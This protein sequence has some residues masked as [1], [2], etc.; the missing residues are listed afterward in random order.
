MTEPNPQRDA[1]ILSIE[2]HLATHGPQRWALVRDRWPDI[3]EASWWRLVARAK[4]K[5]ADEAILEESRRKLA[6]RAAQTTAEEKA[7]AVAANLPATVSPDFVSKSGSRGMAQLDLLSKFES[8]FADAMLLREYAV[9]PEGKI[10]N[11][12]FFRDSVALRDKLLGTALRACESIWNLRRQI[13][14]YD[15]VVEEIAKASP[16]VAQ[17]IMERL[18][19]LNEECGMSFVARP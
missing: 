17:Q 6:E 2:E 16:E 18:Q 3:S 9:N 12:H 11:P 8:L 15:L 14:F 7:E 19:K 5:I 13:S 10:K 1:V 4:R